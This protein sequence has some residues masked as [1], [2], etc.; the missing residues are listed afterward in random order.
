MQFYLMIRLLN[1]ELPVLQKFKR[2]ALV[3]PL[4]YLKHSQ[5]FEHFQIIT[6]KLLP[7]L[8]M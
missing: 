6:K 2:I 5:K 1:K 7:S 8:Q 4:I 3:K